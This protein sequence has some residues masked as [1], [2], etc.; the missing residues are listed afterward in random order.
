M[1]NKIEGVYFD[2]ISSS[3]KN[4]IIEFNERINEIC[5][6]I[7]DGSSF[8]WYLEDLEFEC[9]GNLI[10]IRNKKYPGAILKIDD[11][12]FKIKF[13]KAMKQN[14]RVDIHTQLLNMGLF[15][16]TT[17][18]ICILGLIIISY[19]YILPPIAEKSATL[20]PVS[21]DV[22]IGNMFENTFITESK[23]D[24]EKTKYLEEFAS[25]LDLENSIP[26]SFSVIKSKEINAFALPNG[27]IVLYSAILDIM[28][29]SDELVAL[30]GH[31]VSHINK[32]HSTKILCRNLAGYVLVSLLFNDVNGIMAVL[33][34]NAQQLHSLSF[35]RKFE[36]EADENGLKIL[37]KNNVNPNGI[38]ELFNELEKSNKFSV[39]ELFS[40]HP[41]TEERKENMKKI[42]S[43]SVFVLETSSN[44]TNIFKK[45]KN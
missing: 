24:I 2:G 35:S 43:E 23:I 27:K 11:K 10:E 17:I 42:I 5:L 26:L 31:E 38:V 1:Q 9:Y 7:V 21:F 36:Q 3:L 33:A 14:K 6:Q 16:I 22:K 20:L 41:L 12:N 13:Y 8:V 19:F 25:E 37:I 4:P 29:S 28:K 30:I 40:S 32:R 45:L 18:G 44:L 39:P 34:E 15:K